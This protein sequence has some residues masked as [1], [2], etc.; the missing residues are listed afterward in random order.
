MDNHA[1]FESGYMPGSHIGVLPSGQLSSPAHTNKATDA[2]HFQV[3][4]IVSL[5]LFNV[6]NSNILLSFVYRER[7]DLSR[8]INC[9]IAERYSI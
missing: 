1:I 9:C 2:S 5:T 4:F 8:F 7:P 6:T 3:K